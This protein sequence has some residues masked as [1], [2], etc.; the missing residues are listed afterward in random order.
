MDDARENVASEVI[1]AEA[2]GVVGRAEAACEVDGVRIDCDRRSQ[3]SDDRHDSHIRQRDRRQLAAPKAAP[4]HRG[5]GLA[6]HDGVS[7]NRTRG[8]AKAYKMSARR[9]AS[10]VM[11]AVATVRPR[12]VG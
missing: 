6:L 12:T 7:S 3:Q 8:S 1:G 4:R 2:V 9:L 11:S 5:N 10:S